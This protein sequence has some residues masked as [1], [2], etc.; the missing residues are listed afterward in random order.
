[1]TWRF[2]FISAFKKINNVTFVCGCLSHFW[3]V[4]GTLTWIIWRSSPSRQFQQFL[5]TAGS[6][7]TSRSGIVI[8]WLHK[9]HLTRWR[10]KNVRKILLSM[11]RSPFATIFE[12][13][14]FITCNKK[15]NFICYLRVSK[16]VLSRMLYLF[17]KALLLTG[18]LGDFYKILLR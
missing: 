5:E 3:I 9:I 13:I 18:K 16:S 14:A 8:R 6:F 12:N 11:H 2:K 10:R 17:C 7:Q 1:M 4:C 15:R